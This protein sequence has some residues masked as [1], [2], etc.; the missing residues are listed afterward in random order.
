MLI[1]PGEVFS[2]L[3]FVGFAT[4]AA[5]D[6]SIGTKYKNQA[7]KHPSITS[8]YSTTYPPPN[9]SKPY[10]LPWTPP[11]LHPKISAPWKLHPWD[12]NRRERHIAL[13]KRPEG[14]RMS[15][16]PGGWQLGTVMRQRS[17]DPKTSQT[18]QTGQFM[19]KRCFLLSNV[20]YRCK[21]LN[22]RRDLFKPCGC[23]QV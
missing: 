4:W 1:V 21:N 5:N 17:K 12:L 22:F 23:V 2:H 18:N 9:R 7:S 11:P 15:K 8:K 10:P 13:P 16:Q 14:V 19:I 20:T 3:Q 6:W